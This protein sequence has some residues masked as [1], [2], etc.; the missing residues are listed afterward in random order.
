M[1]H[2]SQKSLV[3]EILELWIDLTGTDPDSK[4]IHFRFGD[5]F[6]LDALS[7]AHSI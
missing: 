1:E 7:A 3:E 2:N 6:S 4:K 5:E